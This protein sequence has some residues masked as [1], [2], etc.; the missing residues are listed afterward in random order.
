MPNCSASRMGVKDY[1]GPLGV[2]A[3]Q[4][5]REAERCPMREANL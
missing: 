1:V 3:L 4:A 2:L 5:A